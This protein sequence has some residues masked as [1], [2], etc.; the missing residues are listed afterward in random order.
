MK[1]IRPISDLHLEFDNGKYTL[2]KLDTDADTALLLVGDIHLEDKA[3]NWIE[4]DCQDFHSIFYVLGNHEHY[5]YSV[6][7]TAKKIQARID[8][9]PLKDKLH[10]MNR[11]A[12]I[13]DDIEFLGCTLWTNMN[14]GDP[15]TKFTVQRSLNDFQHIRN[16]N[17][18]RRLHVE[19]WCGI[20]M[21]DKNWLY[22]RAANKKADKR[23]VMTHHLPSFNSVS[24]RFNIASEKHMNGGFASNCDDLICEL[25]AKMFI[26]GHTHDSCDYQLNETRVICNPRGYYPSDLNLEFND[27]LVIEI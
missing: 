10:L 27:T 12:I 6:D 18:Q 19:D 25:N 23:V 20:H 5:G 11:T 2:P 17:F 16:S 14:D 9:S 22:Q 8:A 7:M 4:R 21:A 15:L 1:Y 13:I 3:I 24:P 26:H